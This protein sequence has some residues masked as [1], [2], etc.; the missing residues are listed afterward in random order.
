MPLLTA[1]VLGQS[2][3]F[4]RAVLPAVQW[5]CH[6]A[7]INMHLPHSAPFM[8]LYQPPQH[9]S[10]PH[11]LSHLILT[12]S[13]QAVCENL[14]VIAE[15]TDIRRGGRTWTKSRRGWQSRV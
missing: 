8:I 11:L 2:L 3:S 15:D 13:L 10:G 14:A 5:R 7:Q 4:P 9:A 6:R 12:T 1:R